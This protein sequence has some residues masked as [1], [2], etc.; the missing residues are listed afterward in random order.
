MSP[1]IVAALASTSGVAQVHLLLRAARGD[2]GPLGFLLRF[3]L[4]GSALAAS[5]YARALWAGAL[6]WFAGFA[7]SSAVVLLAR[8]SARFDRARRG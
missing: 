2:S 4:V 8:G 1:W 5:V 6:G 3:A 7:L